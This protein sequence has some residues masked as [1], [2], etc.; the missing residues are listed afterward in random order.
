MDANTD[1]KRCAPA[2]VEQAGQGAPAAAE[3]TGQ[4]GTGQGGE[5]ER[6][7]E[8]SDAKPDTGAGVPSHG[9]R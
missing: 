4:A 7:P 1:P 6:L 3:P 9:S 2:H 8:H 5:G